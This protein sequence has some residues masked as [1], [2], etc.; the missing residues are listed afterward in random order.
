LTGAILLSQTIA[1]L[2]Y[3]V[4]PVDGFTLASVTTLSPS[5]RSLRPTS[6]FEGTGSRT[7]GSC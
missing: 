3:G 2:P 1:A 6:Q 4:A 5:W 7:R